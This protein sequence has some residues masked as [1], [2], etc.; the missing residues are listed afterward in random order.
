MKKIGA[1]F[2][3][4]VM[5]DV[6]AQ[7]FVGSGQ[8]GAEPFDVLISE[9]MADPLPSA[10][11]PEAE[12]LE[13]YNTC[14]QPV[15]LNGWRLT[16]EDETVVLGDEEMRP[17][18]R[19]IVCD[20]GDAGLF[21]S[22]GPVCGIPA[23]PA[24]NNDGEWLMLADG[25]GRLI[26]FAAFTDSWYGDGPKS[27]GGWSVEQT[28]PS[29]PCGGPGNWTASLDPRGG[30]PGTVNSV[31]ARNPDLYGPRF[32]YAGLEGTSRVLLHFSEPLDEQEAAKAGRYHVPG[33]GAPVE[34]V[35]RKPDM[36]TVELTY[37]RSFLPGRL[38]RMF[39]DDGI[40]DCCGNRLEGSLQVVVAVPQWPHPGDW[41]IN[42]VMWDPPP[43]GADYVE[44]Y[45]HSGEV[46]DLR[47][48]YLAGTPDSQP[49]S[50]K[51]SA[52]S[53]LVL[54]GSRVV[55]T[56]D[57]ADVS[58]R[59]HVACPHHLVEV[60]QLPALPNGQGQVTLQ[61]G[62]H[63]VIDHMAYSEQMH[64]PLLSG[65]EGV[66][67]ERTR[68]DAPNG[69]NGDLLAEAPG[70]ATQRW[71]SASATSGFGTPT[72]ANSQCAEGVSSAAAQMAL[73]REVF[74]PDGDGRN[75]VLKLQYRFGEPGNMVT[76]RIY[77]AMGRLV[78]LLVNHQATGTSGVFTWDGTDGRHRPV[79]AGIYA[80]DAEVYRLSGYS[81]RFRLACVVARRR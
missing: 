74:S 1:V 68:A 75:D 61:D 19:L 60:Q 28:D 7:P 17:G 20:A 52:A 43:G 55:L 14:S 80:L 42:E 26:S 39:L 5:V 18:G 27:S 23:M 64:F 69:N 73:E 22:Y 81:R 44:L 71:H 34:A 62:H 4:L 46:L 25:S 6:H 78:R 11:L 29:N 51:V 65:T 56:E 77:D 40:T 33:M 3:W 9:V 49:S 31:A 72:G 12:Y 32:E 48:L 63:Q 21:E 54:P 47:D 79:A 76:I 35:L 58:S 50:A 57:A 30:T 59:Y 53:R 38:H 36:K 45:N 13:L 16:F 10:G 70:D 15:S 37:D 66:A 67:L 24:I 2:C 41:L 8:P